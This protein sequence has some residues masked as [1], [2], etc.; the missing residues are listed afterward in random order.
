MGHR[1]QIKDLAMTVNGGLTAYIA[2]HDAIFEEAATVKSFL[3]KLSGRAVPISKLL[4]DSE[5]LV[6]LWEA[7]YQEIDAFRH[8]A[9]SSLSKD[10]KYYFDILK[11]YV[12]AIR[13]TVT[14]LVD[15]QRLMNEGSKAG[16]SNRMTWEACQQKESVYQM[17]VQEY[18]EVG[19]ELNAAAPIIFP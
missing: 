4:E 3:R 12:D 7:I 11:R 19:Q 1:D 10:E 16:S 2:I 9:Y 5:R 17:A 13:K 14:A 18:M 6:P 15:R 8:S